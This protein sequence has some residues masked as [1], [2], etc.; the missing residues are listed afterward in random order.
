MNRIQH[1]GTTQNKNAVARNC[2]VGEEKSFVFS[3]SFAFKEM[4][5]FVAKE[6]GI[7]REMMATI[8]VNIVV[9]FAVLWIRAFAKLILIPVSPNLEI[10]G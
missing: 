3:I 2:G 7:Q 5:V 1:N 6:S 9:P 10:M 8:F 4:I